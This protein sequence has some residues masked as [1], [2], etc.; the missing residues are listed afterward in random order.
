MIRG[1]VELKQHRF[2]TGKPTV[3]F[4]FGLSFTN[5][6]YKVSRVAEGV[7]RGAQVVD[8]QQKRQ[9]HAQVLALG[10]VAALLSPFSAQPFPPQRIIDQAGATIQHKITVTNTGTI[11]G[12]D[13]VLG[14]VIPP[15]AG[16]NGVPLQSLYGFERVHVEAGQS[17]SV[18]LNASALEFTQVFNDADGREGES[19]V[20]RVVVAGGYTFQFGVAETRELGQGFATDEVMTAL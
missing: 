13:V 18:I 14:F 15:G 5:F 3:A 8:D 17:V 19:G 7:P 12:D 6:S 11:A 16:Q 9:Q 4:G 2:C 20:K 1:R 10:R